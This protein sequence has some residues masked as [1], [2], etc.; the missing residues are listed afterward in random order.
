M[1]N[2]AI[3]GLGGMGTV[4]YMNYKHIDGVKVVGFV[5][6]SD[7]SKEKAEDL[8]LPIY[9]TI[10]EICK[11]EEVD[12]VDIC[13]PTYLHPDHVKEGLENNKNVICEKPLALNSKD[14]KE[15]FALAKTKG[16]HLYVAQV[17]QFTRQT[18]IL[19]EIVED[20]RFGKPLDAIFERLSE[21]PN[22]GSDSW[23]F[24]K[25]KAGLIPFDLHIH[26]LDMIVSLFN[27]PNKVNVQKTEGILDFPEHYR[28][29][30]NY[31][32]LNVIGEAAWFNAQIPFTARWRVYFEKAYLVNDG[33]KLI[34]YLDEGDK[35]EYDVEEKLKIETGINVPPTQMYLNELKHFVDCIKKD[36]DS[37]IVTSKQVIS[38]IEILE[39]IS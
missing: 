39:S 4:H 27:K 29:I 3:V 32:G 15:L 18:E 23:M 25:E 37:S 14:A 31:E 2:V 1:L 16:L 30:Y 28:F 20:Q 10:S 19:R 34:A 36:I 5:G 17:V 13:T 7:K 6:R 11:N 21:K 38:T 35:I 24:D 8:G 9:K 12:I 33:E 26:D 22:W